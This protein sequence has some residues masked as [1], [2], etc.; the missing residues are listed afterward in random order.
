MFLNSFS[1]TFS[2]VVGLFPSACKHVLI[3]SV[4]EN[5]W[6][7]QIFYFLLS[8]Y[9][10]LWSPSGQNFWSCPGYLSLFFPWNHSSIHYD[11]AMWIWLNWYGFYDQVI[12]FCKVLTCQL[13]THHLVGSLIVIVGTFPSLGFLD[14]T[15]FWFYPITVKRVSRILVLKL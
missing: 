3:S 8:C 13:S 5:K 2:L 12:L 9:T 7:K 15:N 11:Q 1:F 4:L 10:F 6:L 14:I